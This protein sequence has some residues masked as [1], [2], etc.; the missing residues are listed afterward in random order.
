MRERERKSTDCIL[1]LTHSS[2][3][4]GGPAVRAGLKR[5]DIILAVNGQD[6][7]KL[8]HKQ[9]TALIRDTTELRVWLSVCESE[10][11]LSSADSSFS[12]SPQ[13]G[14]YIYASTPIINTDLGD[15]PIKKSHNLL[16]NSLGSQLR[17]FNGS[18]MIPVPQYGSLPKVG[19]FSPLGRKVMTQNEAAYV[20]F[21]PPSTY[22]VTR[23]ST[24]LNYCGPVKIPESWSNRGVSSLCIQEC[25]R[26]LLSKRK[27]ED[28]IKVQFEV[29]QRS[30]KI[31]NTSG[32]VLAKHL[33]QE[34][35]Y[36]GLCS[37]DEHYFAIV[38]RRSSEIVGQAQADLCHV[39]KLMS[40]SKLSTYC[41]NRAK[42]E[43]E[44]RSGQPSSLNSCLDIIDAIQNIFQSETHNPT[45]SLKRGVEATDGVDYGV[46][47][48]IPTLQISG[49]GGS[50][51]SL[52]SSPLQASPLLRRKKSN[53]V[54]LRVKEALSHNRQRSVS[55]PINP[56]IEYTISPIAT[57]SSAGYI[58]PQANNE[59]VHIRVGSD[60]SNSS[61]SSTRSRP[62]P[63]LRGH[64][65]PEDKAKRVSDSSL[66]SMSSDHSGHR[67]GSQ[68]PTPKNTS[69]SMTPVHNPYSH[70]QHI[71]LG[72]K[73]SQPTRTVAVSPVHNGSRPHQLRRQVSFKYLRN[74]LYRL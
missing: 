47:R 37:S 66:S 73:Q 18:A 27:T 71:A 42:S 57:T 3:F 21:V 15:S 51:D 14:S 70:R 56:P 11:Y 60:G 53:V 5:G 17:P 33:R 6:I 34:L 59:V 55:I 10:N 35:Y 64:H 62:L 22:T 69:G 48:G 23:L 12:S 8:S 40:D 32:V 68:S 19:G 31:T 36:C 72:R 9:V 49:S 24:V 74:M 16:N 44:M 29:S 1:S 4:T 52:G 20:T 7:T 46:I 2:I 65:P 67:S 50:T 26:Q 25:A 13:K 38:T 54:D 63:T 28:F 43:R 61:N 39:F 58:R 45:A 30:L 41:I